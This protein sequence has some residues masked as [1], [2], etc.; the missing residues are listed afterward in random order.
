VRVGEANRTEEAWWR[1]G[2]ELSDRRATAAKLSLAGSVATGAFIFVGSWTGGMSLV[3]MWLLLGHAPDSLTGAARWLRF[4][5]SAWDGR[6]ECARCGHRFRALRYRDRG[7]VYL[8]PEAE[9]GRLAVVFRCPACGDFEEGGMTLTGTTAERTLRRVLAYQHFGGA[10]ER[11]IRSATRLIEEAGSARDLTRIVVQGGRR[12]GDVRR[13]G[14][15]AL[16]IAAS[17]AAEQRLLELELADLER[18]WREE[19]RLAEI[20]DGEL[21]P[22]PLLEA[23]RRKVSGQP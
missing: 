12:L 15:I 5:G 22:L 3:G 18:L 11:R 2:K 7:S 23:L 19:E 16:E 17:E 1:Y 9:G 20:I 4:G 14:A 21:T 13:T 8:R 10:S 6:G